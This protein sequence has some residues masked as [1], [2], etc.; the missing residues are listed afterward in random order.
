MP[1][2]GASIGKLRCRTGLPGRTGAWAH[3]LRAVAHTGRTTLLAHPY[4]IPLLGTR[5]PVT[6]PAFTLWESMTFILLDRGLSEEQAADEADCLGRLLIGHALAEAGQP[7]GD[8]GGG[9]EEH[10][11][12]QAVLPAARYPALSRVQQANVVHDPDRIFKLALDGLILAL[13]AHHPED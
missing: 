8:V 3:D 9:E 11:Q 5:P 7:P 10:R 1:F 6:E 12:A 2:A 4:L 13:Q